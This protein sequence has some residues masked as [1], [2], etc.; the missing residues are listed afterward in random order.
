MERSAESTDCRPT[1]DSTP[2]GALLIGALH[3]AT[4]IMAT[5]ARPLHPLFAPTLSVAKQLSDWE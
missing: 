2:L 5:L 4:I 1:A 3:R